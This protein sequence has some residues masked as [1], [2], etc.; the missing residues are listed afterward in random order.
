M[1]PAN[2]PAPRVRIR[3]LRILCADD[4]L[5]VGMVMVHYF[6]QAGHA[7]EHVEDG[8]KA[9]ERMSQDIGHFDVL[10][11]DNQMPGLSGLGLVEQLRQT[12]YRGRIIV[13]SGGLSATDAARYR[14]FG[15]DLVVPKMTP[16]DILLNAVE[17]LD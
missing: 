12:E 6:S 2:L 1:I 8:L 15:V 3:P 10:I 9:F 7:V 17:S 11:T 14:A 16:A 5:R 13:Y 4:D